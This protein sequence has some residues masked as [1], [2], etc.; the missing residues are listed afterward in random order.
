MPDELARRLGERAAA[1]VAEAYDFAVTAVS[2][3][4]GRVLLSGEERLSIV[5]ELVREA[6][7]GWVDAIH[8]KGVAL[9]L[10]R[11]RTAVGDQAA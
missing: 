10:L 5:R 11:S 8:L 4:H 2:D 7:G 9:N 6:E 1:A 3:S